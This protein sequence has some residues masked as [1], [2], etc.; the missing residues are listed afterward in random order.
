MAS[1]R[2]HQPL[3][4]TLKASVQIKSVELCPMLKCESGEARIQELDFALDEDVQ[5]AGYVEITEESVV[6]LIEFTR[7]A[8]S[9]RGEQWGRLNFSELTGV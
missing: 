2:R 4:G 3:S 6:R 9:Q 5:L 1:R 8:K 7:V